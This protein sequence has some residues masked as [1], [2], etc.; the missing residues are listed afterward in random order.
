M[1]KWFNYLEKALLCFGSSYES[2]AAHVDLFPHPTRLQRELT[3]DN[4][5]LLGSLIQSN[6]DHLKRVL[7]L[8]RSIKMVLIINYPY[9]IGHGNHSRVFET[10]Q[11]YIPA[12]AQNDGQAF[13][14][15]RFSAPNEVAD[16]AFANRHIIRTHLRNADPIEF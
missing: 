5:R 6:T 2:N 12:A 8:C 3:P 16:W 13:P 10:L 14:S 15:R 1:H 9:S 4:R 7:K 11:E